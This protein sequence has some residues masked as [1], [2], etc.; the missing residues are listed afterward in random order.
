MQSTPGRRA[1]V[2][3]RPL[4]PAGRTGKRGRF[5][6]L[7]SKCLKL[8]EEALSGRTY[9][10]T[11]TADS[12]LALT[13]R[14]HSPCLL[15]AL[16]SHRPAKRAL[17][18]LPQTSKQ[19]WS[20]RPSAQGHR[21]G[22]VG[23]D[24]QPLWL[25]SSGPAWGWEVTSCPAKGK[26]FPGLPGTRRTRLP[27]WPTPGASYP[28]VPSSSSLTACWKYPGRALK[29]PEATAWL[30]IPV[31][32]K[33]VQIVTPVGSQ[34]EGSVPP[35]SSITTPFSRETSFSSPTPGPPYPAEWIAS[36]G[37]PGPGTEQVCNECS[38]NKENEKQGL[39][40]SW[41]DH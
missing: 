7:A 12:P 11:A 8:G 40:K 3:R 28:Q 35:G 24:A 21:V 29:S 25:P 26:L 37:F 38:L 27:S 2:H 32:E 30:L 22:R 23:A 9:C 10:L 4:S 18:G 15:L 5:F 6:C 41:W 19:V 1:Y 14:H 39:E 31:T 36:L 13:T 20:N 17:V 16:N 34:W 33:K